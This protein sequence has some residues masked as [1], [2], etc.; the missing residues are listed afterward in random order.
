MAFI[1]FNESK[2]Q[3]VPTQKSDHSNHDFRHLDG[4]NG[5]SPDVFTLLDLKTRSLSFFLMM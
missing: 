2:K 5:E 3:I 1:L 4:S